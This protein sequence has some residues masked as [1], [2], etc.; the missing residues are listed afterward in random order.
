[1]PGAHQVQQ[2]DVL[3]AEE[4]SESSK[5]REGSRAEGL[6]RG[7]EGRRGGNPVDRL[8]H[9]LIKSISIHI[10]AVA[11]LPTLRCQSHISPPHP[12]FY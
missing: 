9:M 4:S 11:A 6:E 12:D 3:G 1:V 10:H 2:P 5:S 8:M 7:E